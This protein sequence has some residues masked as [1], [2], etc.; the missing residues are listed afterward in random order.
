MQETPTFYADGYRLEPGLVDVALIYH[1]RGEEEV[2]V[3]L[4]LLIA[5]ALAQNLSQL[6]RLYEQRSGTSLPSVEELQQ[7][8]SAQDNEKS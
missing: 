3:V 8:L 5:K 6:V 7:K 1:L 2:S 4:P